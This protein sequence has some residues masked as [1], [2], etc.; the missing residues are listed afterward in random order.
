MNGKRVAFTFR[1]TPEIHDQVNRLW[2]EDNCASQNDFIEKA[3]RFYIGY[4][5]DK[6]LNVFLSHS[7]LSVVKGT[8]SDSEN[9]IAR[10]L[11]KLAVEVG[12]LTQIV[13]YY[14]GLDE[15]GLARIRGRAIEQV[16]RTNGAIEF[17]KALRDAHQAI[18]PE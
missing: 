7:L 2:R 5:Q 17:E 18:S 16:K 12:I 6:E 15:T 3:V 10:L 13:S 14:E 1:T 11:F 9:R 4:L 8:V